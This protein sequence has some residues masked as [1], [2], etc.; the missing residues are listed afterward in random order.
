MKRVLI[1]L[2]CIFP[3]SLFAL[4]GT[5][6]IKGEAL[7]DAFREKYVTPLSTSEQITKLKKTQDTIAQYLR[8]PSLKKTQHD[9]VAYIG[10]LLC[11]TESILTG[12]LCED[13]YYEQ[14]SLTT[15]KDT[16]SLVQ[17]RKLLIAEHNRRRLGR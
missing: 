6:Q 17:I 16:L 3:A 1:F 8:K 2:L 14:S 12:Y 5:L 7:Y 11:Q 10:H 9:T 13:G 15:K 4:S